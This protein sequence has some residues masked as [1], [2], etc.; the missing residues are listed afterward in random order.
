M[1]HNI[2]DLSGEV[3]YKCD[4]MTDIAVITALVS[5]MCFVLVIECV[6]DRLRGESAMPWRE[7]AKAAMLPAWFGVVTWFLLQI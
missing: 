7:I 3:L 4:V 5:V 6:I 1:A 2:L